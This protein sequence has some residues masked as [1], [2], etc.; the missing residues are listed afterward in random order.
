M[1][2]QPAGASGFP[3]EWD[4]EG[5]AL[6]VK[7][8]GDDPNRTDG[9]RTTAEVCWADSAEERV[10]RA[11][12]V[13]GTITNLG[14]GLALGAP[15][16]NPVPRR[17]TLAALGEV[18]QEPVVVT[19]SVHGGEAMAAETTNAR[20]RILG[21]ISILGTS[22]IVRPFSTASY[23]ASMVPQI[24]VAAAHTGIPRVI[25][26]GMAGKL[27]KLAAGVMMTHFHRSEVDISL[28][29]HAG[30]AGECTL[31][32]A[33]GGHCHRPS[34]LRRASAPELPA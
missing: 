17:I 5:R 18:G 10:L 2:Y 4:S 26:T 34:L 27:P 15:A 29:A 1:A 25:F 16:I 6:V 3:A 12:E 21:D 11:G 13:V 30:A 9:A 31:C 20:L 33:R 19:F 14:P 24:D 32:G 28:L 7:D 22:G 23:R 8:A